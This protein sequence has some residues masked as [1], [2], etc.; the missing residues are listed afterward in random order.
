M[1][2]AKWLLKIGVAFVVGVS[3]VKPG[4][5]RLGFEESISNSS[6][7]LFSCFFL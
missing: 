4:Y 7:G 2:L 1:I 3:K 5:L 6:E